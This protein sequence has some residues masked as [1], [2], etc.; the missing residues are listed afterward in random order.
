MSCNPP[1][2]NAVL[3]LLLYSS[4]PLSIQSLGAIT[5]LPLAEVQRQVRLLH[6]AGC[7]IESHPQHGLTLVSSG[8]GCWSDYIE[9]R[10]AGG[11]GR[12]LVVYQE[13]SSTQD[14]ARTLAS[15]GAD[16][17]GWVV[18]ADRQHGGRGRMG[19]RWFAPAG[20][21]LLLTVIVRGEG[22]SPDRL[23][24]GAC[25]AVAQ[26]VRLNTGLQ[27][28]IRWPND[29]MIEGR[30]LSGTMIEMAGGYA[31][32]GIGINVSVRDHDLPVADAGRSIKATSLLLYNA[33][34]DRLRLL[35]ALL[36]RLGACLEQS[37]AAALH[38]Y[39]KQHT[40]MLQQKI[41]VEHNGLRTTGRVIDLDVE[42]GLLLTD[43]RGAPHT[44]P[45]A[46]ATV[47][48]D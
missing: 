16:A 15:S 44:F 33:P 32:I 17:H 18:V 48:P 19:R 36:D 27:P 46:T 28:Q 11:I 24:L 43:D 41:T 42:H 31:L 9:P 8:L 37:D 21:A 26:S 4:S 38:G 47:V 34:V 3:G 40:S 45:A 10:Y 23:M 30:K 2:N 35:A 20:S 6:E 22:Y 1:E 12:R 7:V 39:W 25:C 29:V 13:T 14:V 5:G